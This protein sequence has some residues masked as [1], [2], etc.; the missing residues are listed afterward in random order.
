MWTYWYY[1]KKSIVIDWYRYGDIVFHVGLDGASWRREA[2]H[3]TDV[4]L[5]LNTK[6][7]Y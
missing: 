3:I 4:S 5:K 7:R 6:Y 2:T 1:R